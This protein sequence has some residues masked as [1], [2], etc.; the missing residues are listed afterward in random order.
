MII[1]SQ[2]KT[3]ACLRGALVNALTR[4]DRT[5]ARH[6]R[7]GYDVLSVVCAHV[8]CPQP[9]KHVTT[10]CESAFYM[11]YFGNNNK[12]TL[13]ICYCERKKSCVLPSRA[14]SAAQGNLENKLH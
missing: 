9:N 4:L 7:S 14:I 11:C 6:A 5:P 8:R 1:N 12:S 13:Y 2:L 3:D 10:Y